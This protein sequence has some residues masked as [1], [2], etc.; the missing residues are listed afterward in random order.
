MRLD[1]VT[2][3]EGRRGGRMLFVRFAVE[4]LGPE[5]WRAECRY[6]SAYLAGSAPAA[7]PERGD[8][9]PTG[10]S[11]GPGTVFGPVTMT[12]IVRY[13]GASGDLNPMHHDDEL[14]RAHGYP[15]AF[16][17]GMMGA[18]Y[19]ASHCAAEYGVESVRRF[20]TRFR[21]LVW[22]GDRLIA[23]ATEARHLAVDGERRVELDLLLRTDSGG[24]AVEGTAEFAVP[25]V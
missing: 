5:G 4:F 13:Q 12:D 11:R 15:A 3:K 20:R 14:A 24:V 17:V 8:P 22:R 19:L 9:G 1:G 6:T 18:G 23:T 25:P 21:D 16:S 2:A 7:P 10:S